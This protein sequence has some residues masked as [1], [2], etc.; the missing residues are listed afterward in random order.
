MELKEFNKDN[1]AIV[2]REYSKISPDVDAY[3]IPVEDF[4]G[5][6]FKILSLRS[7]FNPEL[8][9]FVTKRE[10][11]D[12]CLNLLKAKFKSEIEIKDGIMV[13]L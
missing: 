9:Y 13:Q 2:C 12:L 1:Y 10:N 8:S 6:I 3:E 11:L 5:S 7:R 4:D